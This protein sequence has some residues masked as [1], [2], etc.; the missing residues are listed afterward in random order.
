MADILPCIG[1]NI[2]ERKEGRETRVMKEENNKSNWDEIFYLYC[3]MY[4]V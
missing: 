2:K 4:A 1:F 3:H